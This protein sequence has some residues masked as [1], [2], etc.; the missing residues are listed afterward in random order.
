[1]KSE[2]DDVGGKE[3]EMM[4]GTWKTHESSP[5][6]EDGV[7]W[8]RF[9]E[10]AQRITN[11]SCPI[12]RVISYLPYA[13]ACFLLVLLSLVLHQFISFVCV[14]PFFPSLFLVE[15]LRWSYLVEEVKYRGKLEIL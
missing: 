12:H 15:K 3:D 8:C 9:F 13:A 1:M 10:L 4:E 6:W 11:R 14:I 5:D 7:G 2:A